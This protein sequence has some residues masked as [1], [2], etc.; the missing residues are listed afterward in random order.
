MCCSDTGGSPGLLQSRLRSPVC[1]PGSAGTRACWVRAWLLQ[2]GCHTSLPPADFMRPQWC[3]CGTRSGTRSAWCPS[4]PPSAAACRWTHPA[5]APARVP[6]GCGSQGCDLQLASW[7]VPTEEEDEFRA[8][9]PVFDGCSRLLLVATPCT[10]YVC[11]CAAALSQGTRPPA[12]QPGPGWEPAQ[13]VPGLWASAQVTCWACSL[14]SAVHAVC[15]HLGK[16]PG[17]GALQPADCAAFLGLDLQ[18]AAGGARRFAAPRCLPVETSGAGRAGGLSASATLGPCA[19]L[20]KLLPRAASPAGY[21]P[22][23]LALAGLRGTKAA[24]GNK[25]T[26]VCVAVAAHPSAG[27]SLGPSAMPGAHGL[28]PT[29]ACMQSCAAWASPAGLCQAPGALDLRCWR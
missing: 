29:G 27:A 9:E 22:F 24:V 10:L 6:P 1:G 11:S 19:S 3:L 20:H 26:V 18:E 21:V 5:A 13:G 14:D 8:Q 16:L 25:G 17:W 2:A 15:S 23:V 4:P 28:P 12:A 7:R